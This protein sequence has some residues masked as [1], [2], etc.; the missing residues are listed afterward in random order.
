MRRILKLLSL[1]LMLTACV[2][3]GG[4]GDDDG[5]RSVSRDMEI[6]RLGDLAP[7]RDAAVD[8]A[9]DGAAEDAAAGD[10]AAEDAAPDVAPAAACA[11]GRDDDGD[12]RVD[13]DDR[14]CRDADD[15][16]EGD[17]IALPACD[18]G[19][20]NDGDGRVDLA[21]S[22]CTSAADPREDGANALTACDNGR[23]DDDDG[24]VDFPHD[25]G[26]AA[27]GD[28]DEVDPVAEA[29]CSNGRD[30]DGDGI[31]DWPDDPGCA[32]AGDAD[33]ADPFR[34]P[35][36]DDGEDNDGDG[37]VD[38]ADPGCLGAG[39]DDE[40]G[41]CPVEA[42]DLAAAGGD[43]SGTTAGLVG[44]MVG[45]CGGAAGGERV[46][47]YTV[48]EPLERL[49]FRT[50]H[51]ET[52]R[53]TVLY[54]RRNC[55]VAAEVHCDRGTD[56]APGVRFAVEDPAPGPWYV[57]VDTGSPVAGD[58]RLTAEAVAIAA[59][60]NGRDDDGDGWV[61]AADPGCVEG[62]DRDERDPAEPPV[63]SNGLDDDGDGA[64]DHPDDPDCVFAGGER[65]APLCE[66]GVE[67][68]PI[69]PL[70]GE[71]VLPALAGAGGAQG[72]CGGAFAPEVA[73]RLRLAVAA[74]VRVEVTVGGEVA[75]VARYARR[76]CIDPATEV[77]CRAPEER[78][79]LELF[80]QPAG[81]LYLFVEQGFAPAGAERVARV[82]VEP[83]VGE[84]NDGVDNDG[85][86]RVDLADRGCERP[87]DPSEADPAAVPDCANGLD[88]DGDGRVDWPDD[89]G[90]V[91]AGDPREGGCT[92]HPQW[93]PVGCR[94]ETWVWSSDRQYRDVASASANR[95][96]WTGCSHAGDANNVQGLCSLD[97]TGW[98]SADSTVMR[99]CDAS[100][101]HLGGRHTGNCGGHDGDTVRRLAMRE[102][103]CYDY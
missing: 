48:T 100:W 52:E 29:V 25:P 73:L 90:C 75:Q 33:E 87:R 70:G 85:D 103:D 101:Y 56:A 64:A 63:C 76:S 31:V 5:G 57:V 67:L 35:A 42:I 94:T 27:A 26:C 14:G 20:D 49:V 15:D 77:G 4:G 10:G 28:G 9:G 68:I 38:R 45:S 19:E 97:G 13:L 3:A 16:D 84:C 21:D 59:C 55:A 2:P 47:V 99:G 1:S 41:P 92:G 50:D 17:E 65:E 102:D 51:P 43:Y 32:G 54:V 40:R 11:N 80:E 66:A 88:D 95:A 89:D 69:P 60:R 86:G 6:A 81:E 8:A 96:L 23:D 91:A 93:R 30:D 53:P 62:D 74:D 82:T 18:D 7:G 83:V 61:D 78:A 79:P 24:H 39:G 98:I 44:A 34:A 71:I 37:L 36:C 46:F 12:G 72:R 22:D 58:F